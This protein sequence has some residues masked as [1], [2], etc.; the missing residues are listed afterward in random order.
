MLVRVHGQNTCSEQKVCCVCRVTCHPMPRPMAALR[1]RVPIEKR[2]ACRKPFCLSH[3]HCCC[4]D[5]R[6]HGTLPTATT[7]SMAGRTASAAPAAAVLPPV[8]GCAVTA[9]ELFS[10]DCSSHCE[11]ASRFLGTYEYQLEHQAPSRTLLILVPSALLLVALLRPALVA[12]RGVEGVGCNAKLRYR[13]TMRLVCARPVPCCWF[14]LP[15]FCCWPW[16]PQLRV[17]L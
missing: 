14:W 16:L 1:P 8:A 15:Q 12:G 7:R 3:G 5:I 11:K 4:K 6:S 9:T 13:L 17:A 2:R 10:C